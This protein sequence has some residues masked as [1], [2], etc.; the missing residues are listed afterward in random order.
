[1]ANTGF[2]HQFGTVVN[3]KGDLELDASHVSTWGAVQSASQ[4]AFQLISPVVIDKYGRKWAMY[5][6]TVNV[7]IVSTHEMEGRDISE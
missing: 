5:I 2:V 4:I 3:A 6:L 7:F 1:M